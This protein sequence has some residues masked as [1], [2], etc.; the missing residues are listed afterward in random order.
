M[1][2]LSSLLQAIALEE[3]RNE[4]YV[5]ATVVKVDGS[6][7][8]R[9]GARM[10]I[11]AL[12]ESEGTVSGGCLE[13]DVVR[14]AWWLTGD[15]PVVRSYSTADDGEQSDA[16]YHFAL[17]CQG[18]V[19]LLFER[20]A[21]AA[22]SDLV[23]LL[24]AV[25]AVRR[26]AAVATVIGS[27]GDQAQVGDRL[28]LGPFA[29]MGGTLI[30]TPWMAE[31]LKD[32]QRVLSRGA[33]WV[34]RYSGTGSEVEIF[35][36]RISPAQK[37]VVFGAGHDARPLV[38]FA[39]SLGWCVTVIDSRA[40]FAVRHRF[41][42]A[43]AVYPVALNAPLPQDETLD[44][45]A[46]VVMTH[47]LEQDARWLATALSSQARYVGQLGPR[48]RTERLLASMDDDLLGADALSRLHYPVGLD[49]GG[50]TPESVAMAI[51]AEI[52]AS[53]NDRNG[54]MLKHRRVG[55]HQPL[56]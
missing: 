25:H 29:E 40:N 31:I 33:S 54:G 43:D 3:S 49:L 23:Q 24:K 20:V 27:S 32:L 53:L 19:Y 7:Y 6:A 16:S 26:P 30:D 38:R 46:V 34:K 10:L 39:K 15:G 52:T 50:D 48:S 4:D 44:D 22:A 2:G 55:I 1:A 35:L 37:L 17:G 12:G 9:P 36:E 8:R 14:K 11:S 45:A 13:Q 42:E 28:L 21:Q 41:P 47:S 51:L 18:K 5:L 56:R